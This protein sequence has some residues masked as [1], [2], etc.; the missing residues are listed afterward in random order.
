MG[1]LLAGQSQTGK[2]TLILDIVKHTDRLFDSDIHQ[3]VYVAP[4]ASSADTEYV[5]ELHLICREKNKKLIVYDKPPKAKDLRE[6][7][8]HGPILCL[9]DDVSSY[10]DYP[11]DLAELSSVLVH[12]LSITCIFSLQNPYQKVG[13]LDLVTVSRNICGRFVFYQLN[14]FRMY[15][16]LNAQIFPERKHFLVNCL[17][18]A[19]EAGFNYV[20]INSHPH[21]RLKRQHTVYTGLFQESDPLF[22]NLYD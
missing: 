20:F 3:I 12:H 21:T 10:S 9:L 18:A 19:K 5:K 4:C 13:K 11:Q 8:P 16:N 1:L 17:T 7:F 14:D 15:Q 2:S 6:I 22:F